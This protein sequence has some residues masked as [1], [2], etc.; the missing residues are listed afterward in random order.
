METSSPPGIVAAWSFVLLVSCSPDGSKRSGHAAD[1]AAAAH[2]SQRD[3]P[4]LHFDA[5]ALPLDGGPDLTARADARPDA[6]RLTDA[7]VPDGPPTE[8][9]LDVPESPTPIEEI[10]AFVEPYVELGWAQSIVVALLDGDVVTYLAF[11]AP[12]GQRPLVRATSETIYELGSLTKT[13][14]GL[15]LADAVF[16]GEMN[17][18]DEV[19]VHLPPEVSVPR[20]DGV[21]I[22]LLN[23]ATHHSGLPRDPDNLPMINTYFGGYEVEHLYAFLGNLRLGD[24]PG[25]T[26][27]YSNVGAGLLG[28][29]VTGLSDD[30]AG[31]EAVLRDRVLDP[32]ALDQTGV[33]RVRFVG[34]EVAV[35]ADEARVPVPSMELS[36]LAGAG[37]LLGSAADLVKLL[38]FMIH[39]ETSPLSDVLQAALVDRVVLNA[40]SAIGLHW[41]RSRDIHWHN[42]ATYGGRAF[43][44]FSPT[45][46][47]GVAVLANTTVADIDRLGFSALYA[48]RRQPYGAPSPIAEVP[49]DRTALEGYAGRY[50]AGLASRIDVTI[51]D[52]PAG[53]RLLVSLDGAAPFWLFGSGGDVF[54]F[55]IF[56]GTVTFLVDDTGRATGLRVDAQGQS[57]GFRRP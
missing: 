37:A 43:L 52:T 4:D 36:A 7:R 29:V 44:A 49:V 51:A 41:F 12:D 15:L 10:E 40:Q 56:G 3:E 25:T 32:L 17:L 33:D 57:V 26:Y 39:P 20:R 54:H 8:P 55:R 53:P 5:E 45:D 27:E 18:D 31:Y 24:V 22:T 50:I 21:G 48:L 35:P 16:R 42:G 38:R 34:L 19:S 2:D 11:G 14:T 30:A 6:T 9:D 46:L 28:H 1:L 23:L 13:F 47:K